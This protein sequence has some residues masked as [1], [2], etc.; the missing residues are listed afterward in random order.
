NLTTPLIVMLLAWA[1]L[2]EKLSRGRIF[3]LI[4]AG[5]GAVVLVAGGSVVGS[6]RGDLSGPILLLGS[7]LA[8]ASYTLISKAVLARRSPLLVLAA[9]NLIA[10]VAIWPVALVMGAWSELPNLLNWS[11]AAWLIMAYLVAFMSTTSQWLY[12]RCLRELRASQVSAFLY[13]S[14]LFTAILA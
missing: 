4:L 9:A 12:L 3:G 2:G 5:A 13:L 14:P 10:M 7:A 6:G 1:C 11:P 8:W